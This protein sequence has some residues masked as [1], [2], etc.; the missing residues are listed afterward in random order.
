MPFFSLQNHTALITGAATGIGE[1][2]ARR[3][4]A[5]GANVAIADLDLEGATRVAEA[6]GP[7][8]YAIQLDVTQADSV[9]RAVSATLDHFSSL[10]ILVNN[11]GVGG[12]AAPVWEQTEEDWQRVIGINLT[13]PFLCSRAVIRH[14]RD[15]KYGRLV[16][17]A[18]IAGKEGNP[19]MAA[20]SAS[21]AGL[22]G[23]TKSLAKEVALDGICVNAVT[24]AVVRTRILEQ[25]TPEQVDYMT[26]RIPMQR[27]GTPDEIAAVAHFLASPDCSLVTGQ[28]YDASGGRATY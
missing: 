11:A 26:Q 1:A 7:S 18:S 23:F 6:I 8:A 21:K 27:T 3:F 22:I 12:K 4:A 2:I 19:N 10:E 24:P 16:N 20:Y 28:V 5:A 25:L 9:Q 15:R 17:I 14:M 13:G